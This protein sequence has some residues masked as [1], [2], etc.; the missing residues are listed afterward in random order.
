MPT[1]I[2]DSTLVVEDGS[3]R[4][5]ANSYATVA[6]ADAYNVNVTRSTEWLNA[7]AVAKANALILATQ[8]LDNE[9]AGRWQG[10]RAY[11]E[12]AL[13]WPRADVVDEDGFDLSSTVVPQRLK[14]A[15]CELAVRVVLGDDL[16]PVET[17]PA[18]VAA[19]SV[20]VGPVS[21]SI[22]YQAVR[23]E[24]RYQ[25][26]KIRMMLRSLLRVGERVYRA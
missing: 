4:S 13:A 6:A 25:Y 12:Q 15:C 1:S 7:T 10:H 19:E 14:D 17:E 5:D 18:G 23:A 11:E 26:P 3:G 8:Y 22:T 20:T 24:A 2:P 21:K 16:H 9:F